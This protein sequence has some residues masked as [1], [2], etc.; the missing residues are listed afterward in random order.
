MSMRDNVFKKPSE[1]FAC[2]IIC[3]NSE[4]TF[5]GSI[6]PQTASF[7]K[8]LVVNLTESSS[9]LAYL[10]GEKQCIVV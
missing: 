3:E 8:Y 5:Q 1:T 6:E 2:S 7:S 4:E 10:G 9:R